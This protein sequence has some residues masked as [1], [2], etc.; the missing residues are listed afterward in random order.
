MTILVPGGTFAAPLKRPT[1]LSWPTG[2]R[3][4]CFTRYDDYTGAAQDYLQIY[5][6]SF[7]VPTAASSQLPLVSDDTNE[8]WSFRHGVT[9]RSRANLDTYYTGLGYAYGH[10]DVEY[11][12]DDEA[13]GQPKSARWEDSEFAES[14][15]PLS[16]DSGS[17]NVTVPAYALVH[18]LIEVRNSSAPERFP[19]DEKTASDIATIDLNS[20][21]FTFTLD[22]HICLETDTIAFADRYW[23]YDWYTVAV[24]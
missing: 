1:A 2:D 6:Q 5:R 23:S 9:T 7:F 19:W 21:Q 4:L 3:V 8:D 18:L 16:C 11:N 20:E 10:G 12:Y 17:V 22:E 13:V 14:T 15:F 24:T